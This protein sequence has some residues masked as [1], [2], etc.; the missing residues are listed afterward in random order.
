M[1][2]GR[3][4]LFCATC[5]PYC[6][7]FWH[8]DTRRKVTFPFRAVPRSGSFYAGF[9]RSPSRNSRL[10][11]RRP[12][13]LVLECWDDCVRGAA[14]LKCELL[15]YAIMAQLCTCLAGAFR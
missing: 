15:D 10:L 7:K 11:K 3:P 9:Q 12:L 8:R 4:H 14:V 5:R 6:G 2:P 13:L 1:Q